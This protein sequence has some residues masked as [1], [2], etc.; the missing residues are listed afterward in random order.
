MKLPCVAF[1][2]LGNSRKG[3]L[4]CGRRALDGEFLCWEHRNVLDGVFLGLFSKFGSLLNGPQEKS[5][6]AAAAQEGSE[7]ARGLAPSPNA[8]TPASGGASPPANAA[9]GQRP[10]KK[11]SDIE[12]ARAN[13]RRAASQWPG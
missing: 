2:C 10:R 7:R 8:D 12:K 6:T 9:A 11:R 4:P 5:K 1:V 3:W 13:W